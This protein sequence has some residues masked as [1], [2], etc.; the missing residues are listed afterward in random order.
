MTTS[1]RP[2]AGRLLPAVR[3]ALVCTIAVLVLA[4]GAGAFL[5]SF[6]AISAY[7]TAIGAFP[8]ALWWVP[9]LL[10]DTFITVGTA[11]FLWLS[12][13]ARPLVGRYDTWYARALIALGAG[14]SVAINVAHAPSDLAARLVAALP[15][16]ALLL[17]V[18]L[19]MLI[20][21]RI[22]AESA[23]R[24][25]VSDQVLAS[26]AR[27]APVAPG[28][29]PAPAPPAA[30]LAAAA[31]AGR[32]RPR[33]SAADTHPVYQALATRGTPV[34][35]QTFAAAFDPPMARRTALRHLAAHQ[36]GPS[37]NGHRPRATRDRTGEEV[38]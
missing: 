4:V 11:A 30:E 10:V 16:V 17:S 19:L 23:T 26:V 18:E 21:S 27:M 36:P 34:A 14:V 15:P 28:D 38:P 32:A 35:W 24:D 8:P 22:L 5:A 37:P 31:P 7:A 6:E 3:T 29:L 1:T 33:R 2:A 13:T 25:Q 20:A 9:P 12:L